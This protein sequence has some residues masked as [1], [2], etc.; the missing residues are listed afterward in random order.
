MHLPCWLLCHSHLTAST[1]RIRLS[2][3]VSLIRLWYH[4]HWCSNMATA[5]V[6]SWY[7]ASSGNQETGWCSVDWLYC[8]QQGQKFC[9]WSRIYSW[10]PVVYVLMFS[11]FL[12]SSLF[13][14]SNVGFLVSFP[15]HLLSN[16]PLRV[17]V[18]SSP[19]IPFDLMVSFYLIIS[20]YLWLFYIIYVMFI[21]HFISCLWF[22]TLYLNYQEVLSAIPSKDYAWNLKTA[23]QHFL[24]CQLGL[25]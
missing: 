16:Q 24:C 3:L 12:I 15:S 23:C 2:S 4:N 1:Y 18:V 25:I 22:H 9:N 11:F 17:W 13:S 10:E 19:N 8:C 5:I 21:F 6:W 20:Q 14:Y 7:K